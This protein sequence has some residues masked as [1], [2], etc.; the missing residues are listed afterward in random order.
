VQTPIFFVAIR[1]NKAK[2][3]PSVIIGLP[4]TA[5]ILDFYFPK[6]DLG[7]PQ[8]QISAKYFRNI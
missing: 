2:E 7:K 6:Q 5:K 1:A 4:Y 3:S 8:S